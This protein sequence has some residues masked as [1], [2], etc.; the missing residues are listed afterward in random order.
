MAASAAVAL[1]A[2]VYT[3]TRWRDWNAADFY[4]FWCV[5]QAAGADHLLQGERRLC[6]EARLDARRF[7]LQCLRAVRPRKV[8][9]AELGEFQEPS[10]L[11]ASHAASLA[12]A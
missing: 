12:Q 2:L 1:A 4:Q 7:R 9:G 5:G 6:I 10:K 3:W 8:A 11:G